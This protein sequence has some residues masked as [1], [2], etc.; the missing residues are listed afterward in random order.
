MIYDLEPYVLNQKEYVLYVNVSIPK[1][2]D[3]SSDRLKIIVSSEEA[4]I[5]NTSE[6]K[7]V[8]VTTKVIGPNLLELIY[9]FF[10]SVAEDL[11]LD[12]ILGSYAATF[13]LF[14]IV[15]LILIFI[16]L[17]VYFIKKKFIEIVCLDRIND[18]TPDEEAT[19]D[20]ILLAFARSARNAL[21]IFTSSQF[22]L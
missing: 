4:R 13:L 8:N 3:I 1:F 20:I 17:A 2:T 14:I 11:G 21:W 18:I 12:E 10:E 6:I 19:F 22:S 7:T 16:I 5:K 15:F 9:N